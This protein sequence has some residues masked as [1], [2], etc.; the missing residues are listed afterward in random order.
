VVGHAILGLVVRAN[1][2]GAVAVTDLR[3]ARGPLLGL[4]LLELHLV[5]AGT[6]HLHADLAVLDLRALLLRLHHRVG[7][8]VRDAH[9]G[10]GRVHA[11]TSGARRAVRVDAQVL[12]ADLYVDVIGLG[13]H[14]HGGR[15]GLDAPLALGLWHALDAVD[16]RLELHDR[17]DLVARDLELDGLEAASIGRGR[18]KD[19]DLPLAACGEA[20]VH[21]EEVSREDARLVAAHAGAD[22][23]D[24]VLLVIGVTGDEHDLDLVLEAWDLGLVG[25]DVLLEHLLLAR[26]TGLALHLFRGVDVVEGLDVLPRL[27]HEIG[28]VGVLLGDARVFLGIGSD[29]WVAHLLLKLLICGNELLKLVSHD[30]LLG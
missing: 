18:R 10:V 23:D 21:G 27:G 20:L 6:Q 14:R 26:V 15:R 11:L 5:E 8:Q 3:E 24:G 2:L 30:A 1:L 22:L 17:V 12:G 28:L 16:A 29:G 25:D 9:G 19:L 4:L 7:R 13:K